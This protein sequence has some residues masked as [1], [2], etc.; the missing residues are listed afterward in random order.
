MSTVNRP[1]TFNSVAAG[2]TVKLTGKFDALIEGGV[3]T[4]EIQ[5]SLDGEATWHTVSRDEVGTP[6]SY[7]PASDVAFNGML[8]EADSDIPYR[9]N[10]TAY[11]SGDINCTFRGR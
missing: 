4:V 9:F 3:G 7:T 8:E 10:C 2:A 5:R 6:A 1:E 11:T